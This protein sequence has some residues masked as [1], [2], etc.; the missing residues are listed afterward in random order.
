M[1]KAIVP[2]CVACGVGTRRKN[3]AVQYIKFRLS[4]HSKSM[5]LLPANPYTPSLCLTPHPTPR[6]P[7]Q[8][9]THKHIHSHTRGTSVPDYITA[10]C[11]TQLHQLYI[12]DHQNAF[13]QAAW[14]CVC[15]CVCL[16][17]WDKNSQGGTE[18]EGKT[19]PVYSHKGVWGGSF[20]LTETC[21]IMDLI[22]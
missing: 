7:L 18:R 13:W 1:E 11:Q 3:T 16:Q 20:A 10:L 5:S 6:L 12:F 2:T 4:P 8:S 21:P 15:V 14:V 19:I 9:H 22:H 17:E